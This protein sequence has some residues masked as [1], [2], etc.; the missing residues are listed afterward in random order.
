MSGQTS[1]PMPINASV[2]QGS[3]LGPILFSVFINDMI[4]V[5]KNEIFLY[6]DDSSLF[7]SIPSK[8]D[9]A[10]CTQSI[11]RDLEK[12]FAW[13]EKWKVTFEPSKCKSL[14]ISRKQD[15]LTD[16]LYFVHICTQFT[17]Q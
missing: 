4:N 17:F 1:S 14:T 5:C 9:R 2:P 16:Q 12:I 15:P 3:I 8:C 6:A 10:K 7:C 13:A 11:N